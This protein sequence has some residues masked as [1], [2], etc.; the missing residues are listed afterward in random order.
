MTALVRTAFACWTSHIQSYMD[1]L[2]FTVTS[3]TT[4]VYGDIVLPDISGRTVSVVI[5]IGGV[6]LFFQLVQVAM[7]TT[8]VRHADTSCGLQRHDPDASTAKPAGLH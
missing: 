2:Y 3:L 5:M 1:A 7:R 8:K 6:T 4:T